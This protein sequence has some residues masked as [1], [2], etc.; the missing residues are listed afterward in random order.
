MNGVTPDLERALAEVVDLK[1]RMAFLEWQALSFSTFSKVMG[2]ARL[3][4]FAT[5]QAGVTT[6]SDGRGLELIGQKP[7][8]SVGRDELAATEGTA[9]ND[10]LR[11]ALGGE[12]LRVIEEPVKGVY[13]DTW[14]L[15]QRDERGEPAGL[16][17]LSIDATDRVVSERELAEKIEIVARQTE[18]IR[19]L[20]A[21][22]MKVWQEVLCLPIIGT[23]DAARA[24]DMMDRLLES[25]VREKARF[26]ILDLTGVDVMDTP[27]VHHMLRILAA[28]RAVGADGV[29]SGVRPSVAQS[30]VSLGVDISK[31][32]IMRTLHDALAW[33][34]EKRESD[35]GR[36]RYLGQGA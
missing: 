6:M 27:T 21:P 13:F 25:I 14:Y 34:L 33:C 29:L 10:H 11:R 19:D 32:R 20:A 7:G 30:V 22:I 1:D 23:V 28:A 17:G 12:T 9:R 36:R 18:T 4:L 8:E 16:L 3:I 31:L 15:P 35:I 5:D 2:S 24:S 26:A